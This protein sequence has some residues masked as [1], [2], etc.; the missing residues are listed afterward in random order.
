MPLLRVG[1]RRN[2]Q[3]GRRTTDSYYH[4][5][6]VNMGHPSCRLLRRLPRWRARGLATASAHIP[7]TYIEK[8]VQKYAVD[9]PLGKVVRAGD[10]VM[11]RP[12]RVMTHDNTA[13]VISK[14]AMLQNSLGAHAPA[15]SN[16]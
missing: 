11:I 7:Q 10:Y 8:I 9:L 12:Y 6:V 2:T 4:Q 16:Q 13:A 5:L 15:D 3:V 14:Y 1:F